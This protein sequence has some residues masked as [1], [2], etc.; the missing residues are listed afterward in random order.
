MRRVALPGDEGHHCAEAAVGSACVATEVQNPKGGCVGGWECLRELRSAGPG[1]ESEF[2][3]AVP[4]QR[5]RRPDGCL[6]GWWLA[7]E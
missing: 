2:D 3:S 7:R 1:N 5:F 6:V 4:D